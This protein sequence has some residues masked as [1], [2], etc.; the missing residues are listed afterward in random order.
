MNR[1]NERISIVIVVLT[2]LVFCSLPAAAQVPQDSSPAHRLTPVVLFPGW[3]GTRLEVRV[4]NQSDI[5]DC[6]RSGTFEYTLFLA[7]PSTEFSQVCQDKLLTLVYNFDPQK[8][9][10]GKL[11]S[12]PRVSEQPGVQ[13]RVADYGKTESAPLYAPLFAF[14]EQAGYERNVNLRVAGYDFRLTPDMGGFME[15]TTALIEETYRDNH[16][17]PVHL[18]AH[19][20]GPLYA[21]YL[22]THTSQQWKNKYIHGFTP[23]AGNWPGQGAFYA[24]LFTGFNV[25]TVSFP[26]DPANAASS[27][28]MYESHPSTYMGA[29]DPTYFGDREVVIRV[30]PGGKDFTPQDAQ[31]LFKDAGLKLAQEIAPYYFGF[32]KF[33]PPFFP[34]V[35]VYA[36]KGSGLLTVVGVQLPDLTVGQVLGDA[37]LWIMRDGDSNQEDITN[38]AVLVWQAMPCYRFEFHDNPGVDHVSLAVASPDVWQRLLLHLQQ[39]R[40]E[41]RLK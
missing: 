14:L 12:A 34:Y 28:A 7:Q 9:L 29:S 38:D 30:G 39:P 22:L 25:A 31:Q 1:M 35:D 11:E 33:Q 24:Y 19:S 23:I 26:T 4:H 8:P 41:C 10:K 2:L 27:A 20:N 16:N 15:R 5:S 40:S 21:Q 6:P 3:G 36:E 37:P 18:V 13:V 17:T 32:V